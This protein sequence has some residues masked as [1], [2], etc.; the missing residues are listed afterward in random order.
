MA[1]TVILEAHTPF[2]FMDLKVSVGDRFVAKKDFD[3]LAGE[4]VLF[5]HG[6]DT[7]GYSINEYGGASVHDWFTIV[8]EEK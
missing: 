7:F 6:Q 8:E 3:L 4:I 1:E 2:E 5:E